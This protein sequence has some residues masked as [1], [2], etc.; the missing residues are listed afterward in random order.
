MKRDYTQGSLA[1]NILLLGVPMSLEMLLLSL[2]NLVDIFFI[3]FLGEKAVAAV[4]LSGAVLLVPIAF[5]IGLSN[6]YQM[7]LT[8]RIGAKDLV[9]ARVVLAQVLWFSSVTGLIAG[10]I[11]YL[12]ATLSLKWLGATPAVVA[13]GS[14][15]LQQ[16]QIWM[17]IA[18]LLFSFNTCIRAAA[19]CQNRIDDSDGFQWRPI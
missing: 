2:Y 8:R 5:S 19:E 3:S 16:R 7:L 13:A 14:S 12:L 10:I 6:A 11:G 1:G 15:Y 4:G 18:N 17:I 9:G